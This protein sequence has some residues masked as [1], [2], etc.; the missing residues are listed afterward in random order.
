MQHNRKINQFVILVVC[1]MTFV[2]SFGMEQSK[3]FSSAE[4]AE[5]L[6]TPVLT[7]V[8]RTTSS[9]NLKYSKIDGATGYQIYRSTTKDGT[10]TKVKTTSALTFKDTSTVSTKAYYYKV[11]AYKKGSQKTSYSNFSAR[12]SVRAVLGKTQNLSA[13]ASTSGIK[14]SWNAVSRADSYRI[15]R[16]SSKS[17]TYEYLSSTKNRTYT[18]KTASAGKTYYY[19]VRAYAAISGVKYYGKY[20]VNA[21]A[22][23]A[24]SSQ[25]ENSYLQEVLDLINKERKAEGLSSLTTT[26]SLK[27]AAYKRA[28]ET[29][30]VFSHTRPDGSSFSTVLGEYDI[31]YMACG[32][33]IA[34]GQKTPESV[35]ESWMNSPGH[36]SNILSSKFGKVGI[37]YYVIN[38]TPYWVQ[39]FTN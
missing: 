2:L 15:Y 33:N 17:G 28:V 9:V 1:L 36:R 39:V 13:S 11:R 24:S 10:Y 26:A 25:S 38:N 34:Y 12:K 37:G 31:T 3:L 7:I 21:S 32:E 29:A 14:L 35:M 22:K 20:S 19:K 27:S 18:D 8:S 6:A 5:T 4:A 23:M 16:A 30:S